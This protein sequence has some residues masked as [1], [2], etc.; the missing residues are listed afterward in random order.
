MSARV[1]VIGRGRVGRA[2]ARALA[3]AGMDHELVRGRELRASASTFTVYLLAVPDA[4][5]RAVAETLAPTMSG[6]RAARAVALHCAGARGLNELAPL[7]ARGVGVGVFHPLV[8]FA[9]VGRSELRGATFTAFGDARAT[10]AA[11][12][13][14]RRLGAS[15]TVLPAPPG[16]AYH[17][18]AALVANGAAALAHLGTHILAALGFEQ[19]AGERALAGLLRSVADNVARVGVPAALT[20]PVVR[21]DA[22]TVAAHLRALATLDPKLM[23][24]YAALQPLVLESARAA[25]LDPQSARNVARTFAAPAAKRRRRAHASASH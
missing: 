10:T 12:R 9:A 18:A 4:H 5:I 21:G 15:C 7:A 17:A 8:S 3:E 2:L 23:R 25:G 11:R 20:G 6:A 14:A 13:L 22:A 1:C 24:A 16:P 19:R